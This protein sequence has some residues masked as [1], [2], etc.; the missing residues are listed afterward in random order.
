MSSVVFGR[1]RGKYAKEP[2]P[3]LPEV[4]WRIGLKIGVL[5]GWGQTIRQKIHRQI[6]RKTV[7][8]MGLNGRDTK[9][10]YG[11]QA[12]QM[13]CFYTYGESQKLIVEALS[14][15]QDSRASRILKK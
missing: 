4:F 9:G 5:T 1:I 10:L 13:V 14:S 11:W 8:R 15:F 7:R 3:F 2:R 12:G 6:R